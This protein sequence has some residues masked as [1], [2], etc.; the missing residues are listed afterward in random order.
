[1]K[2]PSEQTIHTHISYIIIIPDE[3]VPDEHEMKTRSNTTCIVVV[4]NKILAN[5]PPPIQVFKQRTFAREGHLFCYTYSRPGAPA[6][7]NNRIISSKSTIPCFT[8]LFVSV[9]ISS[10]I[11]V[12][13]AAKRTE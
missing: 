10:I 9:K 12:P 1:M 2:E 3:H 11:L 8:R 7:F 6:A 5:K 4:T 13:F